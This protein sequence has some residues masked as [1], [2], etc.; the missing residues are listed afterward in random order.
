MG[1]GNMLIHYV[2]GRKPCFPKS[3]VISFDGSYW[4]V[5]STLAEIES[6][7]DCLLPEQTRF[8]LRPATGGMEWPVE[9]C[10]VIGKDTRTLDRQKITENLSAGF[11]TTPRRSAPR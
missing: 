5:M 9:I 2:S 10:L 3:F 6:A 11:A 7:V 1:Q 8:S 4:L